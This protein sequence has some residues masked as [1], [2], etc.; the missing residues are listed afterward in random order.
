MFAHVYQVEKMNSELRL[1]KTTAESADEAKSRF[2]ATV[3]HEI[4]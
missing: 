2:L 1:A 3:S 4:R